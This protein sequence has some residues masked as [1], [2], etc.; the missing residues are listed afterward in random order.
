M[1][2][3]CYSNKQ[4]HEKGLKEKENNNFPIKVDNILNAYA[5]SIKLKFAVE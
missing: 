4:N 3:Y 2:N 1:G 5:E